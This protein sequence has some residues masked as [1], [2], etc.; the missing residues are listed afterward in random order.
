MTR[1]FIPED[2]AIADDGRAV[3]QLVLPA[4]SLLIS[5]EVLLLKDDLTICLF[6]R[7]LSIFSTVERNNYYCYRYIVNLHDFEIFFLR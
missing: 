3:V 1:F 6:K 4:F 2:D 5:D 7:A